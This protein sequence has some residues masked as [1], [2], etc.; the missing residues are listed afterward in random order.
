MAKRIRLSISLSSIFLLI[1]IGLLA[2][3]VMF[4]AFFSSNPVILVNA[5]VLTLAFIW[6]FSK[7]K[8]RAQ[9][10]TYHGD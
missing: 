9:E 8:D 4:W 5:V 10:R 3:T 7:S 6:Y 1:G 2:A